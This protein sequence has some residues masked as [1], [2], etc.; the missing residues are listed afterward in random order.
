MVL[1]A[2]DHAVR[3]LKQGESKV[4]AVVAREAVGADR[5]KEMGVRESKRVCCAVRVVHRKNERAELKQVA[6]WYSAFT[7]LRPVHIEAAVTRWRKGDSSKR[8]VLIPIFRCNRHK[9]QILTRLLPAAKDSGNALFKQKKPREALKYYRQGRKKLE[10]FDKEKLDSSIADQ[11]RALLLS[12]LL[13]CAA[14]SPPSQPPSLVSTSQRFCASALKRNCLRLI[15]WRC[16]LLLT[17]NFCRLSAAWRAAR[18]ANRHHVQQSARA[19]CKQVHAT[20]LLSFQSAMP[21]SDIATPGSDIAGCDQRQSVLP[22]RH[23]A[24]GASCLLYPAKSK[25]QPITSPVQV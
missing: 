6:S 17:K 22:P 13:N 19:G 20:I 9:V 11:C 15:F 21:D 3:V 10:G 2:L 23:G 7:A 25:K 12:L 16:I 1:P 8:Q 5:C 24:Q 18:E 14:C 4:L